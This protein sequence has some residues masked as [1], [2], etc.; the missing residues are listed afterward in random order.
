MR[1]IA[2]MRLLRTPVRAAAAADD[3]HAAAAEQSGRRGTRGTGGGGFAL[4]L[5]AGDRH[6]LPVRKAA[7]WAAFPRISDNWWMS[8]VRKLPRGV[9]V[10][11]LGQTETM[12]SSFIELGVGL[13]MA[14]VMVYLL[15]VVNFQSWVDAFI[16]ITA[17]PAALGGNLLDVASDRHDLE[18]AGND[19]RDHDHG[20][21]DRQQYFGGFV[22]AATHGRGARSREGG[23]RC[24]R[25]P[26]HGRC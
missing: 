26:H 6:I 10:D 11:M 17:L 14:V 4:Q 1:S 15:I 13:V 3:R 24:G 2:W 20:C 25:H 12:H 23:A 8:C 16:I 9:S 7:I 5:G 22:R 18:R 19:G 21:R